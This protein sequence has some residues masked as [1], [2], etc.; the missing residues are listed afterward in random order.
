MPDPEKTK[1]V[2]EWPQPKTKKQ[3][4]SFLGL[5]SYFR[6]FVPHYAQVA[7]PLSDLVGKHKPDRLQWGPQQQIAFDKLRTALTSKPILRA[8]D[9]SKGFVIFLSCVLAWRQ[10][11]VSTDGDKVAQWLHLLSGLILR[12]RLQTLSST[13]EQYIARAGVMC[14]NL[15]INRVDK[16]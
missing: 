15:L 13:T 3:L 11:R 9:M 10:M 4:K 8:P 12:Q 1:A 2:D 14:R 7:L 5:V 16:L 6:N